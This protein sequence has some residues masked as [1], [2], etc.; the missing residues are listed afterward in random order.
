[1]PFTQGVEFREHTTSSLR[2][3]LLEANVTGRNSSRHTK[4]TQIEAI[5]ASLVIFMWGLVNSREDL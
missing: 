5:L 1:M 2:S 3:V 4:T